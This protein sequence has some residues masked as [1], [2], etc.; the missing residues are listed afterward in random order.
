MNRILVWTLW[1]LGF[2][3]GIASTAQAH[4]G[5]PFVIFE[6]RAGTIPVR[7]VVR[8]PD[9]VPGLAEIHVRVLSGRADRVTIL[10]MHW[11]TDRSGAPRPDEARPV[12]GEPGLYTG[13]LWFMARG[14]Y[15]VVVRVDGPGGGELVVPANALARDRKPLPGPLAAFM[16]VLGAGLVI[17][18]AGIGAAAFRE[19]TRSESQIEGHWVRGGVG[20]ALA[21][22]LA[23]GAVW[24]GARW[25]GFVEAEHAR[26]VVFHPSDLTATPLSEDGRSRLRLDID[27]P[28]WT[29]RGW[30]LMPDHGWIL[31]LFLMG[32]GAHPS[33]VHLHPVRDSTY[34]FGADLPPLPAGE[35]RVFADVTHESGMTQTLTN[36]VR[37]GTPVAVGQ[38]VLGQ[39]DSWLEGAI[40]RNGSLQ[41]LGDGLT[42]TLNE[43]AAVAR[44]EVVLRASVRDAAGRPAVLEPYLRMLGHA[45]VMRTDGAVFSHVHPAGNLSLAAARRFAWRTG[46]EESAREV[47]AICGSLDAVPAGVAAALLQEGTVGFPFV[48]PSVGEYWVWVQVRSG[49]KVRTGAFRVVV[50]GGTVKM[51]RRT[52]GKGNGPEMSSPASDRSMTSSRNDENSSRLALPSRSAR[53]LGAG[54]RRVNDVRVTSGDGE[55]SAGPAPDLGERRVRGQLGHERGPGAA[56]PLGIPAMGTKKA[57]PGWGPPVV[58]SVG[59]DQAGLGMPVPASAIL[60]AL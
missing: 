32:T 26:R 40:D 48:F 45:V 37:L 29:Q 39:D 25:W 55:V 53:P 52:V 31:H 4:V 21:V 19:S 51:I 16:L 2:A 15:G 36:V 30:A 6:G 11:S 22:L 1:A 56:R 13:E 60:T 17:G 24:G 7:V 42:M 9:V 20:A 41:A 3:G 18:A 27:D 35:Y 46:G 33:F 28:R 14:A 23:I 44:R 54:F 47:D 12:P 5:T 58:G 59:E 57:A 43:T 34:R 50:T 38:V 49:G 10:P 8:Q